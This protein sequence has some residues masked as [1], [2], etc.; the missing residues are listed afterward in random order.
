M[1]PMARNSPA[2]VANAWRTLRRAV[3]LSRTSPHSGHGGARMRSDAHAARIDSIDRE[4]S[5]SPL[6]TQPRE[7]PDAPVCPNRPGHPYRSR[8][9][10][11]RLRRHR[12]L[13]GGPGRRRTFGRGRLGR[14][15]HPPLDGR[16]SRERRG[17]LRVDG[18]RPDRARPRRALGSWQA[19]VAVPIGNLAP[20]RR[21][22]DRRADELRLAEPLGERD[23]RPDCARTGA[24]VHRRSTQWP[25]RPR[26]HGNAAR[27]MPH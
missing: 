12:P 22:S 18:R 25:G 6:S 9:S 24:A 5:W 15:P 20:R 11:D 17:R 19:C 23:I 21:E 3:T 13:P 14:R 16:A 1:P 10:G 27:A 4:L 8:G 26:E 7:Q 2:P